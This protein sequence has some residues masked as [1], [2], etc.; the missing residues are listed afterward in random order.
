[1]ATQETVET[2][3]EGQDD[4]Q[5]PVKPNV[6][7]LDEQIIQQEL[8]DVEV[9][10]NVTKS[11]QMRNVNAVDNDGNLQW[12]PRDHVTQLRGES[13]KRRLQVRERDEQIAELQRTVDERNAADDEARLAQLSE[14]EKF[15][16][17]ANEYQQ[18]FEGL[19]AE[20]AQQQVQMLRLRVA[21]E[22]GLPSELADRLIGD[23]EE[24]IRQ[25]A[26]RLAELVVREVEPQKQQMK[27]EQV[28][29]GGG[30]PARDDEARRAEYFGKTN[31]SSVFDIG[32]D[33][34]RLPEKQRI[35]K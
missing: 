34:I 12:F 3:S 1:M 28:V 20:N 26:E 8:S 16:E 32:P 15:Q 4:V 30:A 21:G 31:S 11:R 18:K 6:I 14:Q 17:L 25:D 29:P 19:Q 5:T 9:E 35:I 27:T 33:S 10:T 22:V 23:T 24:L 2:D 13:E 7:P